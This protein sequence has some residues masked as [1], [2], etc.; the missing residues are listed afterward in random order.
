MSDHLII[1]L[2][3]EYGSG[4]RELADIVSEKLGLPVHGSDIPELASQMSGIS[5]DHFKKADERPTDSFLYVLATNAMSMANPVNALDNALSGDKLFNKQAEVIKAI[6]EKE[7]CIIVGRC[8][9]HILRDMPRC[10]RIFISADEDFRIKRIM[11]YEG[12]DAK[13]AKKR[14]HAVDKKRNSYFGYY[15]GDDWKSVDTYDLCINTSAIGLEAAANLICNYISIRF[16]EI[17]TA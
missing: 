10:I 16:P 14:M 8:G 17:P 7:S 13:E 9:G 4:G 5:K 11:G 1:S 3:R 6:A 15:A 2:N 12:I